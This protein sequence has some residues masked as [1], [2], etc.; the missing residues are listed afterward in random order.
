MH[1]K[2]VSRVLS[3]NKEESGAIP[4]CWLYLPEDDVTY[5]LILEVPQIIIHSNRVLPFFNFMKYG[6]YRR[7]LFLIVA[8]LEQ[9]R[10]REEQIAKQ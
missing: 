4:D 3:E 10:I 5:K 1:C 8:L 6:E 2:Y 9:I 7:E